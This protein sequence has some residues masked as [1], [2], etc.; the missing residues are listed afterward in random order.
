MFIYP[1]QETNVKASDVTGFRNIG[2]QL[3]VYD[4]KVMSIPLKNALL[5]FCQFLSSVTS[6][7]CLLVAHNASFDASHLFRAVQKCCMLQTFSFIAGYVDTLSILR[8]KT[9]ERNGE[10]MFKLET[11]ARDFLHIVSN[12]N[13]HEGLYDV[14]ILEKITSAKI[15]Q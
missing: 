10:G 14:E 5:A 9:P 3:F 12:D 11:L 15:N 2:G 4:Q 7:P 8:K 6:N 13:F 1:T